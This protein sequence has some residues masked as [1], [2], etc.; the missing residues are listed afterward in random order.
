LLLALA[1]ED[2]TPPAAEAGLHH[3]RRLEIEG[4]L[5]L[6]HISPSGVR[7]AR[8][9]KPACRF[10]LVVGTDQRIRAIQDADAAASQRL[11]QP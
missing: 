2:V 10:E 6:R 9:A 4:F 7:D 5:R 8:R 3:D 11:Q 1:E